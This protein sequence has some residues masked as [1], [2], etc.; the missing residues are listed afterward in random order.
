[1]ASVATGVSTSA[2]AGAAAS[3]LAGAATGTFARAAAGASAGPTAGAVASAS[4]GASTGA[5]ARGEHCCDWDTRDG[6]FVGA[7]AG[8]KLVA[9]STDASARRRFDC[10]DKVS[11]WGTRD[12]QAQLADGGSAGEGGGRIFTDVITRLTIVLAHICK[13]EKQRWQIGCSFF[14]NCLTVFIYIAAFA[15]CCLQEI[16][17]FRS[18]KPSFSQVRYAKLFKTVLHR[19][20]RSTVNLE[21]FVRFTANNLSRSLESRRF[22]YSIVC[23]YIIPKLAVIL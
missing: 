17:N 3:V 10:A 11:S 1:M 13:L 12:D 20:V 6:A 8:S 7:T 19:K 5:S 22:E 14:C 21:V 15:S 16:G 9:V 23:L 2:S 18:A 4:A